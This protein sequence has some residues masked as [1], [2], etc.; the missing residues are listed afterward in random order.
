MR[1]K[2]GP[3]EVQGQINA[4][5]EHAYLH[6]WNPANVYTQDVDFVPDVQPPAS[7]YRKGV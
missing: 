1:Y 5:F 3:Q 6:V 2:Y 4:V 7:S